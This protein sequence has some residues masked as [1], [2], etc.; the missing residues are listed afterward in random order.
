MTR[1][2]VLA[3]G[4]S[5]GL[6]PLVIAAL[7]RWQVLDW[8]NHRSS[9]AA[10]V[11]RGGGIAPVSAL[12]VALSVADGLTSGARLALLGATVA[13]GCVGL[14]DDVHRIAPL[15]RLGSQTV[16]AVALLPILLHDFSG[17]AA[18]YALFA[19][20]SGIWLVGYVNAFNFMDGINGLAATQAIIAGASWSVLGAI[21]DSTSLQTGGSLLAAAA[22]GFLFFNF[23]TARVFLGD[24]G[25][26]ALGGTMAALVII[27]LRAGVPPEAML[28]PVALYLVDTGATLVMRVAAGRPWYEAHREHVYQRLN[29]RGW[30]H[31]KT[32]AI[33]AMV[34]LV[35]STLGF[36]SLSSSVAIRLAADSAIVATLAVYVASP[37]LLAGGN[38]LRAAPGG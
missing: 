2:A 5:L 4:L 21:N 16:I 20:G 8:P 29:A 7:R 24:V 11:P 17:T 6:C 23:P 15:P 22:L 32:T 36:L 18:W 3:F 13:Y 37:R 9:H 12:V 10:P 34:I 19:L 25:S 14:A 30:G 38:A 27:G 28:A 35:T 33:V 26:Y 1:A 31:V